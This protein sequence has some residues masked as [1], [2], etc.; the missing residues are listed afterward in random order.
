MFRLEKAFKRVKKGKRGFP[1][2]KGKD[3]FYSLV[4]PAM[5]IKY[6]NGIITIPKIG[7]F[8]INVNI[9]NFKEISIC[10]RK[11]NYYLTICYEEKEI[12]K[13][14]IKNIIAID[15]GISKYVSGVTNNNE[16]IESN[17]ISNLFNKLD[18]EIDNLK[19]RLSKK[20]KGSNRYVKLKKALN[21]LYIYK[22]NKLQDF[23]HK[24]SHVIT[25]RQ[26]NC[27]V[28]GD[29]KPKFMKSESKQLNRSIQNNW[30]ISDFIS[31]LEY[32]C[33][34]KGIHFFKINESWTSKKCCVCGKIHDMPLNKR[35]MI[36]ECGN[37][38]DRDLNSSIN[39]FNRFVVGHTKLLNNSFNQIT[40][41][42]SDKF[43]YTFMYI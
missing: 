31:K 5:Y 30:G 43:K 27:V 19:S 1:R 20:K 25:E 38:L 24:L 28:V 42:G 8:K 17:S 2:F 36:C 21:K 7:E 9:N 29:L 14:E 13:E 11:N 34:L 32:K 10:K 18:K 22:T 40:L 37:N 15:L 23:N 6:N 16:F 3:E 12:R 39:I 35:Q 41:D 33:Q 26:E 4:F